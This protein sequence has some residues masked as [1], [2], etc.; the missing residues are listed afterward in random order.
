MQFLY[1]FMNQHFQI[2]LRKIKELIFRQK[3]LQPSQKC[4]WM[5]IWFQILLYMINVKFEFVVYLERVSLYV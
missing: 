4:A 5:P 2:K 3:N 1:F